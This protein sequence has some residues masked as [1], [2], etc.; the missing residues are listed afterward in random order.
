MSLL[1]LAL[2]WLSSTVLLM[3]ASFLVVENDTWELLALSFIIAVF[4]ML[5]GIDQY[6]NRQY[7]KGY[8]EGQDLELVHGGAYW[9]KCI[10]AQPLEPEIEKD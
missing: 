7:C 2:V 3:G 1:A 10:C 6:Q 5:A 4:G 8:C 9:D